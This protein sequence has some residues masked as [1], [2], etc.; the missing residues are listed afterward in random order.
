MTTNPRR[1]IIRLQGFDYAREGAYFIT[2]CTHN[3]LCLLGE[4][5]DQ[6]M[7]LNALGRAIESEWLQTAKLRSY[8]TLDY[9][10]IMPNH[11]HAV[12]FLQNH[13]RAT[14]RVAPTKENSPSGPA[15]WSVGAIV[16][17]FK[18]QVT[19]R[20]K[21]SGRLPNGRLWQRSY[22]EHVVRDENDLNRIRQYIEDNAAIWVEDEYYSP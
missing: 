15:P 2:I 5:T 10:V 1:K 14:R 21:S 17:Q 8:V 22:Y 12:F 19:R 4:V 11:F 9:Y 3:R 6:E 13:E 18:S 7:R 20:I 16:A